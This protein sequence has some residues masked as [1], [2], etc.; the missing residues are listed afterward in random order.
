MTGF[1]EVS[2]IYAFDY[3][4]WFGLQD[5]MRLEKGS[6]G[7]DKGPPCWFA[8]QLLTLV[9]TFLPNYLIGYH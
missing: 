1:G 2:S 5:E 7:S 8:A 6:D 4:R 3:M 9:G